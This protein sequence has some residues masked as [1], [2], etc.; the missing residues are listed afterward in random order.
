MML[1]CHSPAAVD[2]E[3]VILQP[4]IK[5]LVLSMLPLHPFAVPLIS[6][7]LPS[8]SFSNHS[9]EQPGES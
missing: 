1:W 4:V 7:S 9:T 6:L 5:G 2:I 3:L 8:P